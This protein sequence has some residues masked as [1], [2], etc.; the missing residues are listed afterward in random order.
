MSIFEYF[1]KETKDPKDEQ[2]TE[3]ARVDAY[4]SK[5]LLRESDSKDAQAK[6]IRDFYNSPA[7]ANLE[8]Q[9]RSLTTF[10]DQN[11][12]GEK[13]SSF[14]QYMADFEA[15][16]ADPAEVAR[17]YSQ[18][19]LLMGTTYGAIDKTQRVG[20]AFDFLYHAAEGRVDQGTHLTCGANALEARVLARNPALGAEMV[21]SASITG[22][23]IANDGKTIKLDPA[24]LQAHGEEKN[25]PPVDG[26]RS[27][28]S[29]IFQVTAINDMSQR[30]PVPHSFLQE[31]RSDWW[32]IRTVEA[33]LGSRGE[34]WRKDED[35]LQTKFHGLPLKF[36]AEENKRLLGDS[37]VVIANVGK[38]DSN[39]APHVNFFDPGERNMRIA[40]AKSPGIQTYESVESLNLHLSEL[41]SQKRFPIIAGVDLMNGELPGLS[42]YLSDPNSGGDH[43][44][45]LK[46]YDPIGKRVYIQNSFGAEYDG[47]IS[48][49]DLYNGSL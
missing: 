24:S 1:H 7:A 10:A 48:T 3:Q 27:Q 12:D 14:H 6:T 15:K 41:Q 40:D 28:A 33:A 31:S 16:T 37:D 23:W 2:L 5:S 11:F 39:T 18:L 35:G 20:T 46:G 44:L 47:W 4:G 22:E 38:P 45:T 30:S 19:N 29:Q 49:Q 21:A 17:T 43:V 36:V 32:A 26:W 9:K 25:Y 8:V 34:Y 42:H 13:K